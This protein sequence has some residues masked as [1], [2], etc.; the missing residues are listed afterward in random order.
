MAEPVISEIKYLGS[1]DFDMLEVRV[2]DD[3]PDPENL[4]L[5]IYDRSHNG[6][7]TASPSASDIYDITAVGLL[8]TEDVDM[9]GNDDDGTLHYT[10]GTDENGTNIKLHAQ[11]AVGLY[12]SDTGETYG[13]YS[14]GNPYTVS[15]N[16]GDPFAG[17]ATEVLDN[18]G[19]VNGVTSLE[20]QPG[21]AYTTNSTPDPGSSYICFTTDTLIAT[22]TGPRPVQDLQI[23]DLVRTKDAGLQAIRWIGTRRF[24]NI[25]KAHHHLQPITIKAHAFGRNVPSQDTKLSP[26]HAVL[27]TG[28]KPHLYFGQTE[29]LAA[30]KGLTNSDFVFTNADAEVTYYHILLDTHA[31]VLANDMW[32]ESLFLG[33]ESLGMLADQGRSEVFDIFPE[34]RSN[35]GGYG[36]KARQMLRPKEAALLV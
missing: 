11:D 6:S 9:D 12:N 30:A 3:Y 35:L 21:G 32:A 20:R 17:V 27:N 29:V 7:T 18:S 13:L 31:L 5:V 28:W 2:P 24:D 16:S 4:V 10:I 33:D 8:Y 19:Q 36:M 22:N 25:G 15:T 23:G 26:N 34:L 1:G 14:W